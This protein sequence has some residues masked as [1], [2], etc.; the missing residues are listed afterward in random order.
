MLL[1]FAT[2]VV[3]EGKIQVA[4]AKGADLPPGC[5]LDKD[6]KPDGQPDDFYDGGVLLP[7]GGHKGYA[8]AMFVEM[9]PG[10]RSAPLARATWILPSAT[11]VVAK[12]ISMS[13]FSP[14]GMPIEIGL[15]EKRRLGAAE[16]R[17]RAAAH[18]P[19]EPPPPP[20]TTIAI[21]SCGRAPGWP[22]GRAGRCG[23]SARSRRRRVFDCLAFLIA[24]SVPKRGRDVAEG[25]VA[26][27]QR[28]RGRLLDDRRPRG[29]IEPAGLDH[30]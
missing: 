1:D 2:T 28:G 29:R 13:A 5:I 9:Q 16:R 27:D 20:V 23:C 24:T 15:V 17:R 6:G 8:L 3:A 7:F 22:T 21:T 10:G 11:T 25:P 18:R 14:P 30:G 26:V 19:G 12:S 4:R